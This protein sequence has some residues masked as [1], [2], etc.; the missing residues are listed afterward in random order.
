M[1]KNAR[2]L[3]VALLMVFAIVFGANYFS[4]G[5]S[6][7]KK[8]IANYLSTSVLGIEEVSNLPNFDVQD[9]DVF[10][11]KA[12][13]LLSVSPT[14]FG[15]EQPV[16]GMHLESVGVTLRYGAIYFEENGYD[17][18]SFS[19]PSSWKIYMMDGKEIDYNHP[20]GEGVDIVFMNENSGLVRFKFFGDKDKVTGLPV[21]NADIAIVTNLIRDENSDEEVRN[22]DI[23]PYSTDLGFETFSW[24]FVRELTI[25]PWPLVDGKEGVEGM[26]F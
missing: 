6:G 8:H 15:T 17:T 9:S 10:G 20:I 21:M 3:S 24:S 14:G 22:F 23:S 19:E 4:D 2:N 26:E 13:D 12:T 7:I 16:G 1:K 11:L 18:F 25:L 5:S